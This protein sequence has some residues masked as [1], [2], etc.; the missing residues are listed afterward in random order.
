MSTATRYIGRNNLRHTCR[1]ERTVW[2]IVIVTLAILSAGVVGIIARPAQPT[3]AELLQSAQIE[4]KKEYQ[5]AI[6]E[7]SCPWAEQGNCGGCHL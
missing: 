2:Q 5:A 3:K 6:H 4:F 1:K 7:M